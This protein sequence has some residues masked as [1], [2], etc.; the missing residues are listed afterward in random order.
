MHAPSLRHMR[1][2]GEHVP[3]WSALPAL[4]C[5]VDAAGHAGARCK[6]RGV[7]FTHIASLLSRLQVLGACGGLRLQAD[8]PQQSV[9][10]VP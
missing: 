3:W 8:R 6:F 10:V 4:A 7:G 1:G 5:S 2:I 9:S